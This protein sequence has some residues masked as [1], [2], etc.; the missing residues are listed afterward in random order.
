MPPATGLIAA[1]VATIA[2]APVRVVRVAANRSGRDHG[3]ADLRRT[4]DACRAPDRGVRPTCRVACPAG[5]CAATADRCDSG[6][7][8]GLP[9]VTTGA[10]RVHAGGC[11]RDRRSPSFPT[12]WASRW[13]AADPLQVLPALV[14]NLDWD[15]AA[16]GFAVM[17]AAIMLVA[18]RI[19]VLVPGVL[20]AARGWPDRRTARRGMTDRSSVTYPPC[21]RSPRLHCHGDRWP[22]CWSPLRSSRWLVLPNQLRSPGPTRRRPGPRGTQIASSSA[23]ASP[24][25][26]VACSGPS[27]SGEASPGARSTA[28]L[29]REDQL[30][31][32]DHGHG[33]A[34]RHFRSRASCA[35]LPT[36]VLAAIIIV[37]VL[38]LVR[39]TP[40]LQL[41]V[42]VGAPVRDRTDDVRGDRHP[43]T[44]DPVRGHH[45]RGAGRAGAPA[46]G[47]AGHGSRGGWRTAHCT[48]ARRASSTSARRTCW[49]T[50]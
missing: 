3:H 28:R 30:E 17:T 10:G 18:R 31:R 33:R 48:C 2:A 46:P 1:A 37:A 16:I 50:S 4:G 27:R 34:G 21:F 38:G 40:I 24:T 14:G 5:G 45:W 41:R 20:L 44:A 12:S 49:R 13:M 11:A 7:R 26:P 9:H 15:V 19:H 6:W 8:A 29:A 42:L 43:C 23:R 22:R 39:L 35:S 25:S 47:A 32:P 36:A